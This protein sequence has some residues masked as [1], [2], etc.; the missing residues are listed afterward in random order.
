MKKYKITD[1]HK[2]PGLSITTISKLYH[3]KIERIDYAKLEKLCN[4]FECDIKD[5]LQYKK[6]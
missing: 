1:V 5:K 4:L 2:K 6:D 3:D